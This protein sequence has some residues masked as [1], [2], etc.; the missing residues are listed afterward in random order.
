MSE[1]IIVVFDGRHSA[2]EA[3]MRIEK[4]SMDWDAELDDVIVVTRDSEG[5]I[6]IKSAN[7]LTAMGILG[8]SA[9][10][11][12]TGML[13]GALA[14]NPAAGLLAGVAAG[15]GGGAL[16]GILDQA[17]EEDALLAKVGGKLKPDSS[18]LAMIVWSDR[19]VKLLKELESF[20][21]E[22]IQTSLS[23]SDEEALRKALQ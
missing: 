9:M 1:L 7:T 4:M 12:L 21:G 22:V 5:Q 6:R 3:L 19:P 11:G 10:G 18:A 2:E 8:G 23:V 20:K 16:A 17:D 15:T 13:F 14:G